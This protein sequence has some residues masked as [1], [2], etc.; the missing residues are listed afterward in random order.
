MPQSKA[1]APNRGREAGPRKSKPNRRSDPGPRY[2]V[3]L[4]STVATQV[5]RYAETIDASV[6]KAI[7]TLVRLG[8]ESQ[9]NRRHEFFQRLKENLARDDP[10]EQDRMVDEFRT[11][12]L[13]R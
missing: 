7:A 6:S 9:A 5:E 13:G 2:S 8:L 11:L 1:K 4:P 10:K 12:I 3:A